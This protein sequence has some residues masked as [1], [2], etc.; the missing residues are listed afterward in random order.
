MT[1]SVLQGRL[2]P[3]VGGEIM[4]KMVA[5]SL[6]LV[7]SKGPT[8]KIELDNLVGQCNRNVVK[9]YRRKMR[10]QTFADQA[11]E[12]LPFLILREMKIKQNKQKTYKDYK[13]GWQIGPGN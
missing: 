6:C 3:A 12:K 11:Q 9:C 2:Y 1:N 4:T 7:Q 8:Q 5:C 10:S 13:I